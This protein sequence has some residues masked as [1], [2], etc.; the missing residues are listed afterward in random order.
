M[1]RAVA[2]VL[3]NDGTLWLNLGDGYADDESSER[4]GVKSGDL[5]GVPWRYAQ[6][7]FMRGSLTNCSRVRP[8]ALVLCT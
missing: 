8:E 5:I 4:A 6:N 1:F 7:T 2:R 3:T